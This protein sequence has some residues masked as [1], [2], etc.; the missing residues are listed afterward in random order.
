MSRNGSGVY[1]LPGGSIVSDGQTI[2][3]TQHNTPLT[4]LETDMNTARPI[5]AGG[6]GATTAAAARAALAIGTTSFKVTA[7]NAQAITAGSWTVVT[8]DNEIFDNGAGFASNNFTAPIAGIYL[9]GGQANIQITGS[10]PVDVRL[11]VSINGAAPTNSDRAIIAADA[12]DNLSSVVSFQTIFSLSASDTVGL[13]CFM[14]TNGASL[15]AT[16]NTVFWG[17]RLS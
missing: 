15:A 8:L 13:R 17:I 10:V 6:T 14:T 2:L 5:V 12:I 7:A 11:G 4:D 16:N 9:I 3:A 1:S